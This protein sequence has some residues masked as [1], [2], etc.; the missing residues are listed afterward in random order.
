MPLWLGGVFWMTSR[1][2]MKARGNGRSASDRRREQPLVVE[3]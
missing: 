2:F 3:A 1:L